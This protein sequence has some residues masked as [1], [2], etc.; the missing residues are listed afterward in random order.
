MP[1]R[2]VLSLWFPRLGAERLIR[3]D[4]MLAEPPF[5][6]LR[7]TGQ[8]Q[9]IASMNGA[10][11]AEGL[12]LDQPLRDAQAMCPGLLTRLQNKRAEALFLTSLARWAGKFSP[13]VAEQT[14]A[15]LLLDITGCAHLYGGEEA[16]LAQVGEDCADLGLTVQA[17]VAD[18]VGA[19]WAL[20]RYAGQPGAQLRSGDAIDQEA[21]ATRS[22][23]VKRRHWERGGAAPRVGLLPAQS[24]RIAPPGQTYAALAEL[25]VVALR[26]SEA[27]S[28]QLLR[29]GI[30]KIGDLL[31]QPRAGLARRFGKDLVMRL[32]QAMGHQPEPVSPAA[33]PLRFAV[34]L[35]FPEPIGLE[36][37]MLAA[38]DRMLPRL[39]QRLKDKAQGARLLRLQ[40]YR[41]D[42][43]MQEIE[44]GLARASD[45]PHR[46]RPLLA[47]KLSDLMADFG[48]DML[49]LE[50]PLTE[51]LSVRQMTGHAEAG[52][53]VN[54]RLERSTAMD[55]LLGRIGARVGLER[56]TRLHPAESHIPEK[57]H[58]V[59]AAAWSEP[60][61][62]PWPDYGLE[63]PALLWRPE[64][65]TA[66]DSPAV[67]REFRW[68][69]RL[70][71]L[72]HARGPERLAPEWWLDEPDWRSG[73]RD[74]WDITCAEGDR[75]WLYYAHG[76]AISSGW[77]CQGSFA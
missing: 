42:H 46:M 47:M 36:E 57:T 75:L 26:L 9:V 29:L 51:H 24:Y 23:A 22:R 56:I 64:T 76:G 49:R 8:M 67:P 2:R 59:L 69:G 60:F 25:P 48:F 28:T 68:R 35:S 21:R 5:A 44:V 73:T 13:W 38:L 14:P 17:G 15:S 40:A 30:R 50:A 54:E 7:D 62:D 4:P 58:T 27:A 52:R 39:C 10:A 71:T 63:R 32:D 70:L 53:Q 61:A 65:V 6:V 33:A 11:Q 3:Q 19:A 77:Y 74:Y 12:S 18:T 16:M 66:P 34:R 1:K 37:D 41:T 31:G 20:A 45:D 43:S 55:D 72:H